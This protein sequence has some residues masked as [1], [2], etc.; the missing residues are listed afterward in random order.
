[1]DISFILTSKDLKPKEKVSQLAESILQ[2]QTSVTDVV[3][4]MHNAK[5]PTKGSCMEALE[6]ATQKQ[7][8]LIDLD[9]FLYITT[10]LTAKAPRVKWESAKVISNTASQFPELI[11]DTINQLLQNAKDDGTVVRWSVAY[12]LK[13]IISTSVEKQHWKEKITT[14]MEEE[15][16]NSIKKMYKEALNKI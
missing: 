9:T 5:D 15:E 16:K 11:E 1:M 7:P 12:A 4:F 8:N 14:L 2:K 3:E 13:S 10:C 6:Y